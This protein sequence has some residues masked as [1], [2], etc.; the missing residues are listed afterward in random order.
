VHIELNPNGREGPNPPPW[1]IHYV[2]D[3]DECAIWYDGTLPEA[4]THGIQD[5]DLK[6]RLISPNL[7]AAIL[8]NLGLWLQQNKAKARPGDIVIYD[9]Y[10]FELVP[11][12][13]SCK[14]VV[15]PVLR[16]SWDKDPGSRVDMDEFR[17]LCDKHG[18]IL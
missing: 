11:S 15:R 3:R 13:C 16:L 17:A 6:I 7:A 4:H 10:K 9:K 5:L 1:E 12:T 8:D 2:N 18:I 14:N